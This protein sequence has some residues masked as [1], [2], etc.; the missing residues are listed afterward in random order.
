VTDAKVMELV[1]DL[2]VPLDVEDADAVE[3]AVVACARGTITMKELAKRVRAAVAD[4]D[5]V[6]RAMV[7]ESVADVLGEDVEELWPS[8]RR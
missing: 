8:R 6:T 1:L 2:V 4:Y 7:C 5:A 3:G